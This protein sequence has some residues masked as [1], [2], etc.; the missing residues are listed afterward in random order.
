M[1][2]PFR[3]WSLPVYDDESYYDHLLPDVF[4]LFGGP[5]DFPPC[6]SVY[7]EFIAGILLL[8]KTT[9]P[10]LPRSFSTLLPSTRS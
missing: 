9:F 6:W 2:F 10:L 8:C 4:F 1:V 5:E 3:F 7:Y